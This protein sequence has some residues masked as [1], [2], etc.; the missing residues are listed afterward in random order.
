[1]DNINNN[2]MQ[3]L[4]KFNLPVDVQKSDDVLGKD[5]VKVRDIL[6]GKE[7]DDN[8]INK[9]SDVFPQTKS[10]NTDLLS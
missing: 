7:K 6:S 4:Q 1:M 10:N 5:K 2:K 9:M 3:E 8:L